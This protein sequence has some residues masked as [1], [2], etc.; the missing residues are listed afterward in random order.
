MECST[1]YGYEKHPIF[2][3]QWGILDNVFLYDLV[4]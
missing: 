2:L 1:T 3:Q 4:N